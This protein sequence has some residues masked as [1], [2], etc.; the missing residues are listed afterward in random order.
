MMKKLILGGTAAALLSTVAIGTPF[1]SYARTGATWISDSTSDSLPIEWELKR[2]RQMITDLQPEIKRAAKQIAVEKVDV[3]RLEKQVAST[4]GAL[5]KSKQNIA[6]L[7]DDLA[8]ESVTYSYAGRTYTSAQVKSDLANRFK[9]H[10][11]RAATA[12]KLTQM[13]DSRRASLDSANQR[14]EAMLQARR[15][16]EVEVEHLTARCAA[17][18]VS[19]TAS[20]LNLDDSALSQTRTL[21]DDIAA[22]ID[23][24]E[25]TMQVDVE[26]FGGIDLDEPSE[27]D[28]MDEIATYF[29]EGSDNES[30]I[31]IVLN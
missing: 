29:G 19:Q 25:E 27:E 5:A 15:Q 4:D 31:A 17:L 18:R 2:A 8:N 14:M 9:R 26:Y 11:T 10:K 20:E 21:L 24:E 3:A 16:L 13:L 23:V 1:M 22:R 6:R 30:G 7:T 12:Q 28:L